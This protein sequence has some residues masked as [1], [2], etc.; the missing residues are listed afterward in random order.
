MMARRVIATVLA[1]ALLV[2]GCDPG[3][4]Q[5]LDANALPE[6]P[7]LVWQV[8]FGAI[9]ERCV[10]AVSVADGRLGWLHWPVASR[11]FRMN[12]CPPNARCRSPGPGEFNAWV[13]Y[14]FTSGDPMM[15]HV[16]PAGDDGSG[17][18]VADELEP[19]PDWLLKEL[20]TME[21]SLAP[22]SAGEGTS[23]SR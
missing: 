10:E 18:L 19:L 21:L 15:I 23:R 3:P 22:T 14:R 1:G 7:C 11:I 8:A 17:P 9:P 5:S 12:M 6:D 2:V 16:R 4:D 20:A 13:I